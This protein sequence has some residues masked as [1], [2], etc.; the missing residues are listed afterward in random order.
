MKEDV[1][2][3]HGTDI[4]VT[5]D[6]NRCIH[7]RECVEGLPNVFDPKQRPW[8]DLDDVDPDEVADVVERCPTGALHYERL[9][10]ADDERV[11]P[12]NTVSPVADGPLYLHG[13]FLV[14][15]SSGEPLLEDTRIALCRCGHSENKPLCD[16]SHARIFDGDGVAPDDVPTADTG[17]RAESSSESDNRDVAS[18]G[19]VTVTLTKDGPFRLDGPFDLRD[20]GDQHSYDDAA[21]CRC[22]GSANKPFCDGSHSE[23]GF[24]TDD[25]E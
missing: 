21:L 24:S 22:G 5:Y 18:P 2:R 23:R 14:R 6:S 11:P 3:Y 10:G 25:D 12:R 4:E 8:I 19:E 9:D 1:H 7:A 15:T 20:G 13:D 17:E 16:N